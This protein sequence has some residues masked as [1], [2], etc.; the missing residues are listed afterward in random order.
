[1][2]A[3]PLSARGPIVQPVL[4][5]QLDVKTVE[6]SDRVGYSINRARFATIT[7]PA[8]VGPLCSELR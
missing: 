6:V 4:I 2:L 5:E 7:I 3:L 8:P 1:M